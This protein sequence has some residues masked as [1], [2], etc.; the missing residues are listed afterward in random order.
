VLFLR[1]PYGAAPKK[2]PGDVIANNPSNGQELSKAT[3][4]HESNLSQAKEFLWT[5]SQEQGSNSS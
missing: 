4:K 2:V 5:V 3:T 1:N